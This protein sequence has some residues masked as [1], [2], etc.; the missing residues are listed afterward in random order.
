[1]KSTGLLRSSSQYSLASFL[2]S[3]LFVISALFL[4]GLALIMVIAVLASLLATGEIKA[5][6]TVLIAAFG[7]EGLILLPSVIF[8]IQKF[9]QK[10]SVDEEVS[11]PISNGWLI[12]LIGVAFASLLTGYLIQ[13]ID[14]INW[15]IFPILTI[16]AVV[17]PLLVLWLSGVKKL[18]LGT[19]WQIGSVL[20][21]ALTLAPLILFALEIFILLVGLVGIG[22]YISMRP[23]LASEL[24][25]LAQQVMVLG[26]ESM[27]TLD[28]ILPLLAKPG[29]IVSV[30]IYIAVLVPALEEIFKPL[31]VWLFAGKLASPAQG[32]ALGALSGGAYGLIE[33]LNVSSQT[34]GWAIL[35]LTR[36]CT[37]LLHITTSAL[38]GAAIVT[39]WRE[40]RYLRFLGTYFLAVFLHGLWNALAILFSYSSLPEVI[41]QPLGQSLDRPFDLNGTQLAIAIAMFILAV[42]FL[43]ILLTTNRRLRKAVNGFESESQMETNESVI[44]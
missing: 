19:R 6:Q 37:G 43:A 28:L 29:V 15:I 10:R 33:T 24:Q 4:F 31:G 5:Q 20:G 36:I 17:L 34:D 26:P 44:P 14:T 32:F 40:R 1:M 27:A 8:A 21:L 23:E 3:I 41:G 12:I 42:G 18:P 22:I 30:L 11:L 9:L 25:R 13:N 39:V 16:P 35:L 2:S 7:F 38:M